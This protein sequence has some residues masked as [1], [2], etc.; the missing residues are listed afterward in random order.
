MFKYLIVIQNHNV[1]YSGNLL[2]VKLD[3]KLDTK[4]DARQAP[5]R[6]PDSTPESENLNAKP[7]KTKLPIILI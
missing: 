1:T 4:L 3:A 2:D 6:R 7:G 5:T